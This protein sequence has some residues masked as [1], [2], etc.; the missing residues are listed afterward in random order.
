[1][2]VSPL[3]SAEK[4]HIHQVLSA[5]TNL[6]PVAISTNQL[7]VM[8]MLIFKPLNELVLNYQPSCN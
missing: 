5:N 4:C 2:S 8:K 3:I 6:T 7:S 1:M